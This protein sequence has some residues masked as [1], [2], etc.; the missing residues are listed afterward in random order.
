[1]S[2]ATV[3]IDKLTEPFSMRIP[4]ITKT[5]LENLTAEQ[6]KSLHNAMLLIIA[7]HLHDST[8]DPSLYLSTGNSTDTLL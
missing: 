2:S 4:E 6:K 1:M 3:K 5:L 7:K 8:F